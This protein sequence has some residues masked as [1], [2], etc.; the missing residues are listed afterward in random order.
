MYRSSAV[1][2]IGEK[3]NQ[4]LI[5]QILNEGR[6]NNTQGFQWVD[7]SRSPKKGADPDKFLGKWAFPG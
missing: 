5:N 2:L 7:L 1:K 3:Y 6:V 4:A